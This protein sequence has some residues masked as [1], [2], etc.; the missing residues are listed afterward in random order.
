CRSPQP[1]QVLDEGRW[2]VAVKPQID[3]AS[4]GAPS[5]C[6]VGISLNQRDQVAPCSLSGAGL[7]QRIAQRIAGGPPLVRLL[8]SGEPGRLDDVD[9]VA[10][11]F[12]VATLEHH[13]LDAFELLGKPCPTQGYVGR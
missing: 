1:R 5:P 2:V 7:A 8:E 3:Q 6:V 10:D 13:A 12:V 9:Q 11:G 4:S